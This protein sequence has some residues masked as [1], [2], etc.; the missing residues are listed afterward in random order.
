MGGRRAPLRFG[1]RR[2]RRLRCGARS[3]GPVAEL[4]TLT[5]FGF[6]QTAATSQFLSALRAGPQALCSSP[7]KRRYAHL[8]PTALRATWLVCVWAQL[9]LGIEMPIG[10]KMLRPFARFLGH[11]LLPNRRIRRPI[12]QMISEGV[13]G[14]AVKANPGMEHTRHND[15]LLVTVR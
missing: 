1:G 15:R 2:V 7:P 11:P 3:C 10:L 13:A 4:A 9:V 8:P 5:S 14:G 12:Q 6:A